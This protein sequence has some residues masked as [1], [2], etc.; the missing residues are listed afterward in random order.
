MD[1]FFLSTGWAAASR[2]VTLVVSGSIVGVPAHRPPPP[3][4]LEVLTDPFKRQLYDEGYDKE[5]IEE[6]VAAAQRAA[7]EHKPRHHH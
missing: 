2:K 7:H 5:A 1:W 4:A 6:R 3:Q